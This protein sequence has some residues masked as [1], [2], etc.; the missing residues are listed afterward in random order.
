MTT[1]YPYVYDPMDDIYSLPDG[2]RA[3]GSKL[4][5]ILHNKKRSS[6]SIVAGIKQIIANE[7]LVELAPAPRP[8][9]A[10][11]TKSECID[12]KEA[13]SI[14]DGKIKYQY[15]GADRKLL[16]SFPSP[17]SKAVGHGEIE[18]TVP[19]FTSLCPM[20]GQPDFATIKIEYTPRDKCVE[21]RSLKLY[22]GSFRQHGEFH[23]ACVQRIA[24]DLIYLLDPDSLHVTGEFSPRGGIPFWPMVSYERK[25][26]GLEF[27]TTPK[28]SLEGM[29]VFEIKDV[30]N[31]NEGA[32]SRDMYDM[33]WQSD[34]APHRLMAEGKIIGEATVEQIRIDHHGAMLHGLK[35]TAFET[36][37]LGSVIGED[38][39]VTV[40]WMKDVVLLGD[41]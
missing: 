34:G 18:I 32:E 31:A 13:L 2:S 20:T 14:G 37:R 28:I 3:S 9:G 22:L 36:E 24:N 38:D 6:D 29:S 30:W 1:E 16:E 40:L 10:P 12:E 17:M 26:H 5:E 33:P 15:N 7:K 35:L 41:S 39:M 8:A 19:E 27:T 23:E 4:A 25:F 21:S 11:I